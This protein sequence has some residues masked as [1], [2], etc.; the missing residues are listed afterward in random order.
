MEREA[1]GMNRTRLLRRLPLT[2]ALAFLLPGLAA[3]QEPGGD[4]PSARP[5]ERQSAGQGAP[6]DTVDLRT[7]GYGQGSPDAPVTV[8]EFSDFG[9]P[10]CGRFALD[11]YPEL[12]REFVETGRVHWRYVPFVIGMFPNGGGAARAA[13]CA[14]EQDGFW[15]MHHLLYE[16][17]AQWKATDQPEQL[18]TAYAASLELDEGQFATCYAEDRPGDR[19]HLANL[20]AGRIGIRGTPTFLINGRMLQGAAPL[21]QF[22]AILE[23]LSAR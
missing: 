1:D 3:C 19:I 22:R 12:H 20:V 10:Y 9:C 18:F 17:Q 2:L 15:P 5:G 4:D 14:A 6:V 8:I 21:Q 16:R 23:G 7:L 13:E 11:I